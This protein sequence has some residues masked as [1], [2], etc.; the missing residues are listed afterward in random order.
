[1]SEGATV[2]EPSTASL[3]DTRLAVANNHATRAKL[4]VNIS[5]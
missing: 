5:S 3:I 1:M 2:E 4:P